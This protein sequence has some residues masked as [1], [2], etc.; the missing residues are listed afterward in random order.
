MSSRLSSP[1]TT[2]LSESG[3]RSG[4]IGSEHD[5]HLVLNSHPLRLSAKRHKK[6]LKMLTE[7]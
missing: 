5:T 2:S 6:N 3:K 1:L 4:L 7:V